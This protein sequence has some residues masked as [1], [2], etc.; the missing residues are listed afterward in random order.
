M[1]EPRVVVLTRAQRAV[2]GELCRD[3]A[4]NLTIAHRLRVT[5][6][7]VKSHM[8]EVFAAFEAASRAQVVVDCLTRRVV[9]KTVAVRT[10]P[11]TRTMST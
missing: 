8:R 9:V 11:T 3:G 1:S 5:E 6:D 10:S 7:T 4:S 2:L